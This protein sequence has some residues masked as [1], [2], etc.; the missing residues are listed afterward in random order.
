[1]NVVV[2]RPATEAGLAMLEAAGD[3]ADGV[4]A[5]EGR[6]LGA[7]TLISFDKKAVRLIEAQ[8]KSARLLA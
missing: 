1:L 5:Y 3:F 8:G 4:I 6:W 2:N 7:D